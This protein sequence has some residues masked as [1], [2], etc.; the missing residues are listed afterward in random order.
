M[1]QITKQHFWCKYLYT[2]EIKE[3]CIHK[4]DGVTIFNHAER[5]CITVLKPR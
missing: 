1:K 2:C 3:L 4:T 5:Y